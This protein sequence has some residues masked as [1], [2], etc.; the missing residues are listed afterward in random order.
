MNSQNAVD[1]FEDNRLRESEESALSRHNDRKDSGSFY[2]S[3]KRNEKFREDAESSSVDRDLTRTREP[4]RD[5]KR[6][7]DRDRLSDG[8]HSSASF[9]SDDYENASLSERSFS[10]QSPSPSAHRTGRVRRVSSS[11]LHRTGIK[12][13]HTRRVKMQESSL[14]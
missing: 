7:P 1:S 4:K 5:L 11:P 8:E 9:Y 3:E 13:S 14:K 10:P 12:K 2:Q 6:D